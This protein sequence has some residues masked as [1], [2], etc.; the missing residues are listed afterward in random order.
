MHKYEI[1]TFIEQGILFES[2]G[3]NLKEL[4]NNGYLF[5]TD[6]EGNKDGWVKASKIIEGNHLSESYRE[7]IQK[8]IDGVLHE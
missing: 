8:I 5:E 4:I 7:E 6:R 3:N 1:S 2:H